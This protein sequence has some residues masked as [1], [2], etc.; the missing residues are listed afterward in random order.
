MIEL[1]VLLPP[2]E[3]IEFSPG[4]SDDAIIFCA[5]SDRRFTLYIVEVPEE[6]AVYLTLKYGKDN[7][8]KR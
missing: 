7:V 5:R 8:W 3:T 4:Q 2:L 6:E 1:N